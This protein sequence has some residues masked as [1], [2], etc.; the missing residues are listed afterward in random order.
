MGFT[1]IQQM[2]P[3]VSVRALL[4]YELNYYIHEPP[5]T[6]LLSGIWLFLFSL[7]MFLF[8]TVVSLAGDLTTKPALCSRNN[9]FRINNMTLIFIIRIQSRERQRNDKLPSVLCYYY[10]VWVGG[11]SKNLTIPPSLQTCKLFCSSK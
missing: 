10:Y 9:R 2:S 5:Y 6:Y 4:K 1:G 3:T 11:Y 7:F 8:L